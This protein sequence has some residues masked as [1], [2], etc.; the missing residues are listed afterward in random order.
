MD[1]LIVTR[2]IDEYFVCFQR[3]D[4]LGLQNLVATDVTLHDWETKAIGLDN[5]LA[6]NQTIFEQFNEITIKRL[7]TDIVSKKVFCLIEITLDDL[8]PI[9]VMDIIELTEQGKIILVDAYRQ[10]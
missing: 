10:F 6:A 9:K 8:E 5:F 2:I 7:T 3:K 1:E 4:I